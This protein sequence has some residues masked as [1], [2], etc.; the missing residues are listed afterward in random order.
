MLNTGWSHPFPGWIVCHRSRQM[1]NLSFH[2]SPDKSQIYYFLLCN[3][4]DLFIPVAIPES[5]RLFNHAQSLQL[6]GDKDHTIWP[7]PVWG[8]VC[9]F[10]LIAICFLT[11]LEWPASAVCVLW[12]LNTC[13]YCAPLGL[14][15]WTPLEVAGGL[16]AAPPDFWCP[17]SVISTV[18][19]WVSA[20]LSPGHP[21]SQPTLAWSSHGPSASGAKDLRCRRTLI[22]WSK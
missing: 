7:G 3:Y 4:I 21:L 6:A 13:S 14:L 17:L 18:S 8:S 12:Q 16:P 10:S 5:D 9:V 11:C 19:C 22:S 15:C 20:W 2:E 1:N